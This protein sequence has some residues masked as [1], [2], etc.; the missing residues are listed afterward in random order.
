[1]I[2]A[3]GVAR[4]GEMTTKEAMGFVN[5]DTESVGMQPFNVTSDYMQ[6]FVTLKDPS[7]YDTSKF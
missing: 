6:W 4:A 7:T 3:K 2:K 5:S 1:M